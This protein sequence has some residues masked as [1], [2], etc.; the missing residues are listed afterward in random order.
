MRTMNRTVVLY[1]ALLGD[2]DN[3]K[4]HGH[5]QHLSFCFTDQ[6]SLVTRSWTLVPCKFRLRSLDERIRAARY[7]KTHPHLVLPSHT[8]SVWVDSSMQLCGPIEPMLDCLGERGV[9]TFKYPDLYGRR[10]CAFDEGLACINRG[11]DASDIILRQMQGYRDERFPE[12]YGLAETT[13][14]V[15]KNSEAVAVLNGTWWREICRGSR[16]DQL[17]FDY[18]CWRRKIPYSWLPGYRLENPFAKYVAHKTQVYSGRSYSSIEPTL[19]GGIR[20]MNRECNR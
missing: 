11:K 15:R 16:R 2:Y 13:L 1:T 10:E 9:A 4:E 14:M 12:R 18:S 7:Y 3:L 8:Y 5:P 6:T 20:H 17:S 19:C